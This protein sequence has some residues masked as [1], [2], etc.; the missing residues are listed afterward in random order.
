MRVVL[1][2]INGCFFGLELAVLD[3]VGWSN[4]KY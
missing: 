2:S 4:L 3:G 1:V